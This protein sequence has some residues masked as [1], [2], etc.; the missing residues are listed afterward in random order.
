MVDVGQDYIYAV[1]DEETADKVCR[2]LAGM[3]VSFNRHSISQKDIYS[4]YQ[5]MIKQGSSN[6]CAIKS[7][8]S[9]YEKSETQI[10]RIIKKWKNK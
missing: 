6:S 7:L 10:Y 3:R 8:A 5:S 1:L 4:D 2:Y 9:Q